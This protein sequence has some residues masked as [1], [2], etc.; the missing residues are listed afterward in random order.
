MLTVFATAALIPLATIPVL[1]A[2][3]RRYGRLRG[4][5][6]FAAAGL[7]ASAVALAAFTVFPLP[8]EADL[9]CSAGGVQSWQLDLGHSLDELR[10][11][12]AGLGA[13]ATLTSFTFWQLAANVALFVPF[14]FFLHQAARWP[15]IAV[16]ATSFMVSA[17]IELSQGTAFFGLYPC[18]YRRFDIDDIVTNT[19]GAI[20]GVIASAIIG[21]IFSFTRPSPEPDLGPPGRIRRAVAV[22]VDLAVGFVLLSAI[23]IGAVMVWD[24]ALGGDPSR[25]PA[26]ATLTM[27]ARI[28]SATTM[29]LLIPL[30]RRDRATLGQ[31]VMNLAPVREDSHGRRPR[32]WS[33]VVRGLVRWLPWVVSPAVAGPLMVMAD[34][35][36]AIVRGD[37][38]SITALASAS[39][40]RSVPSIAATPHDPTG[41]QAFHADR[42]DR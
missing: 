38:R 18:P 20:L 3:V 26:S 35:A 16:V 1:A 17:M 10:A 9:L 21:A 29:G 32:G 28:A 2:T 6:L 23:E 4:W 31:A 39:R 13:T 8:T 5:P 11:L 24:I 25:E 27:A 37:R 12:N 15:A 42:Y 30:L 14:G 40:V 41:D 34:G 22:G 36:S 19:T 33:V 7:L